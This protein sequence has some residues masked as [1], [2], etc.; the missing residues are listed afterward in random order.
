[1]AAAYDRMAA[2]ASAAGHTLIV[3]SGFRSDAE[4]AALFEAHPDPTWVAPPGQ[5]L[6]RCATELDLGPA[7]APTA[8]SRPRRR[9]SAS[10]SATA[11]SPGTTGS[12][13]APRPARR[14]ASPEA[15]RRAGPTGRRRGDALPSFVPARYRDP[16]ERSAARWGVSGAMLAAQLMAESGFNPNAVSPA[17]A[18]GIAQFMP[19]T[20]ASMGL[21][22]PFDPVAAIDAQAHLMSDLLK[23]LGSIP[24]AL[25]AYN[26]GPGSGPAVHVHP[27]VPRDAGLRRADPGAAEGDGRAGGAGAGGAAGEV[28]R[29][30]G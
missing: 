8:G 28:M 1:M 17:G 11:G 29:Q 15:R 27:S 19:G 4:Q 21:R 14:R 5:S 13:P 7:D 20:A 9:A 10:S 22:D 23:Q 24:L 16:I 18:Q 3:N 26:A 2:A 25:A 6:H 30:T 12:T